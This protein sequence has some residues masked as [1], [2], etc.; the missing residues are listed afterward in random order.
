MPTLE[1]PRPGVNPGDDDGVIREW[2]GLELG[3]LDMTVQR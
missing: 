2:S 1:Q 3:V